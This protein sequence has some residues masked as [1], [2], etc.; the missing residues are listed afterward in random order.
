MQQQIRCSNIEN[1]LKTAKSS[2]LLIIES[3]DRTHQGRVL[4]ETHEERLR[5]V[6]T[7]PLVCACRIDQRN[8]ILETLNNVFF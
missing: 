5:E 2:R 3:R 6:Y 4:E 7:K 1:F 8:K